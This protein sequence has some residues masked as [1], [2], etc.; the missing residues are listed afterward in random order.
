[1]LDMLRAE[2][3]RYRL[4]ALGVGFV[5]LLLLVYLSRLI[6]LPQ[7]SLSLLTL[8]GAV[9][10]IAGLLFG[11]W[12]MQGHRRPSSWLNLL[13]RPLAPR[14]IGAAL[15]GA[16]ALVMLQ[17]VLLPVL[18]AL[19]LMAWMGQPIDSLHA[20]LAVQA[21]LLAVCG[22]L[23]GAAA[24]LGPL[25]RGLPL[26]V[27]A[28]LLLFDFLPLPWLLLPMSLFDALL[29]A[30]LLDR[31]RPD[32]AAVPQRWGSRLLQGAPLLIAFAWL[33][34]TGL[35][36]VA[37]ALF[38]LLGT[39]PSQAAESAA[40]ATRFEHWRLLK[41]AE[42][43]SQALPTLP[44]GWTAAQLAEADSVHIRYPGRRLPQRHQPAEAR[45]NGLNWGDA[46]RGWLLL[47]SHD[48][49]RYRVQDQRGR[50]LGW[51]GDGCLSPERDGS[52]AFDSPPLPL[53]GGTVAVG[54]RLLRLPAGRDCLQTTLQLP[55]S[56]GAVQALQQQGAAQLLVS[57]QAVLGLGR[58]GQPQWQL[59]LPEGLG[60][61]EHIMLS[62]H[63][64]RDDAL[65]AIVDGRH[66]QPSQPR[67]RLWH[68]DGQGRLQTLLERPLQPDFPAWFVW[69]D[70]L[71]A[72]A[73]SHLIGGYKRLLDRQFGSAHL[74]AEA[75]AR[76]S[77]V[78]GLA[79]GLSLLA[80]LL[81]LALSRRRGGD[82]ASSAGW[83]LAALTLGPANLAVQWLLQERSRPGP[84]WAGLA[85]AGPGP[86]AV[87]AKSP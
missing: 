8:V 25:W 58:D 47:F 77:Q 69:G 33:L 76:S 54:N 64:Q 49:M 81:A 61:N 31:F 41:P 55:A 36:I 73:V 13:H 19:P 3:R 10:L 48:A 16:G 7:Q 23:A 9:Y 72:P 6:A 24:L 67:L 87:M 42:L 27:F 83:A 65:L 85:G 79:I 37:Q 53:G 82:A 45:A 68:V 34:Q 14:R 50:P 70:W 12:Q 39:H 38:A 43:W 46:S 59:D 1:M 20:G 26:L 32:L 11:A 30:V 21:W 56:A 4:A 51:L 75:P 63:R 22:Y 74:L 80:G 78:L 18:L 66:L 28:P 60:L 62:R 86:G 15:A 5:H 29:L 84:V 40:D 57:T 35:Q 17:T 2:W 44:A 71:L 52:P